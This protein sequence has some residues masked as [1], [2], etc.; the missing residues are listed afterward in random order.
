MRQAP[1]PHCGA[2]LIASTPA[3]PAADDQQLMPG[4]TPAAPAEMTIDGMRISANDPYVTFCGHP[5]CNKKVEDCA[6][7]AAWRAEVKNQG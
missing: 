6:E 2:P 1:C 7:H 5:G 4:S 3:E